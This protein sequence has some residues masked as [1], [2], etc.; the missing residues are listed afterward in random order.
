[1][2]NT[3]YNNWLFTFLLTFQFLAAFGQSPQYENK[4]IEK[5][6]ISLDS[7]VPPDFDESSILLRL[8]TKEGDHFSQT[9]FDNDLKTLIQDFDRVIPEVTILDQK[10]YI[11]LKVSLKPTIQ[12]IY[13]TG[14]Q[15]IKTQDLEKELG[16]LPRTVFDRQCFNKAFHKLKAYYVQEGFF[17][18]ELAYEVKLNP[19]CNEVNIEISIIEGRAGRVKKIFFCGFDQCDR[20]DIADLMIT[21]KYN[22]LTSWVTKEGTYNEDAIQQD[23]YVILN[24]LQ[25]KG[26]ADA[27]VKIDVCEANEANRIFIY[28]NAVKG[29]IYNIGDITFEGNKIFCDADIWTKIGVQTGDCYSPEALRATIDKIT[30]LYGKFG[31]IDAFVDYEPKLVC[32][33]CVYSI[34]FTIHEGESF[35]VGLIKVLGNCTT[36]TNVILHETLLIPGQLFNSE[37]LEATESRLKNIGFFKNVNVYAV[38]SDGICGLGENYRDVHI[39]VEETSTG[40]F[41]ASVGYSTTESLFGGINVTENNFNYKGLPRLFSDGYQAVRGGGE[42]AHIT[43]TIGQKSRSY[44]LSWAKPYFRDTQW[45]I[46]FDLETSSNR[47]MTSAYDIEAYGL[48]LHATNQLNPF[49]RL[50]YHYRLRTTNVHI[51]DS[52]KVTH[53]EIKELHN[54]GLISAVGLSIGYDSTDHP[55]RPTKGIKSRLESEFAG[56]GGQYQFFSIAYLNSYYIQTDTNGVLKFRADAR[57]IDPMFSTNI[58]DIPIDERLFLGGDNTI[59]GFR[60]YNVGPQFKNKCEWKGDP[61]ETQEKIDKWKRHCKR[62]GDPKGG[63]S[64]QFLSVEYSRRVLK[65]FDAFVFC[66]SGQLS[67]NNWQIGRF[68]TSIGF[69][70]RFQV[71]ESGPP[72]QLGWGFPLNEKYNHDVKRFFLTVGGKF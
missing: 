8:K 32:D 71:F 51:N 58:D 64:L 34:H 44:I 9:E 29:S 35:R 53:E 41:G 49:M 72:L 10:I 24:Y 40:H 3:R 12:T 31:Y 60:P 47:Y 61:S 33:Q 65:K 50:G 13:W 46:G 48:T 39:E 5:I 69:G 55:L 11:T 20:D 54:D 6:D 23:Q 14:N 4:I 7:T 57:F 63:I 43:A 27:K 2:L 28:V 15:K 19:G 68:Y 17:E 66:D 45:S 59:R 26:Y 1:M 16:I 67:D 22:F 36:D 42:Y 25:N 70:I 18:A 21:K 30:H 37:R 38:K 52:K 56:V 62:N